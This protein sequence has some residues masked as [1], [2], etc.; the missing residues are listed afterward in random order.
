MAVEFK[1]PDLG[2]NVESGDVVNV[3]VA[4]GDAL[5]QDQPVIELETDKA[6]IEVPSPLSG[7]VRE[8]HV[9]AGDQAAVGQLILTI[10]TDAPS[11]TTGAPAEA[12]PAT[13]AET[14]EETPPEPTSTPVEATPETGGV[15]EFKL[16][17]LGENVE[18]GDVI[19]VL[20]AVGD[21]LAQDQPVIE[22]ETDKAVVEVPSPLS[23]IVREVHVQAGDQAVVGQLLLTVETSA[24]VDI[25]QAPGAPASAESSPAQPVPAPAETVQSPPPPASD[26][27][28]PAPTSGP[29]KLVP[30]P[31][32]VRRLAREIGIDITQV[33]GSG[34]GGRISASDVKAFAR[35]LNTARQAT[36]SP[37]AV[38]PAS[39][40]PDF[41]RW[42]EVE[43]RP[44]GKVRQITAQRLQAAWSS[45]PMVTQFDKADITE[46]EKWRK[47]YGP[48]AEAAGGK[49]TPTAIL[50]KLL[51]AALKRFPQFNCSIDIA[52][53]EIIQKQYYNIGI[54]VDTPNGLLVPVVRDV[55]QKNIIE[56]AVELTEMAGKTRERK[57][58][59]EDMQGGCMT[60]SNVG[61]MGGTGFTPI[62]NPPEVAILGVARS[63][64]EPVYVDGEFV[65]RMMLPLALTYDH[66]QIDGADGARFLRWVAQALEDP[67]LIL[68]EG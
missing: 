44:M 62:V 14:T 1:L 2:E 30:A 66:R 47:E 11:A 46:M 42:G 9:Q 36:P 43:R 7:I 65:P 55:D 56:L 33:A 8:I 27:T 37:S 49:L 34:P 48:R 57:I 12:S 61:V 16:P 53:Q 3:L 15:A 5:A 25:P 31:P 59:P 38:V 52:S 23:G 64:Y 10:E 28:Y 22:L 35:Q 60:I 19:N 54:A 4:V 29:R 63:R 24:P 32:S 67:F 18:S 45:I 40:L 39:E 21:T 6:V 17:D 26:R 20:V 51:A 58:T 41:S 13:T 68:L 50:I